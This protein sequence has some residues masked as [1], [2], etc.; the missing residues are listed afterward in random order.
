MAVDVDGTLLD[1]EF[2]D[3]MRPR[4]QEAINRVREAGHLVAFCTGRNSRSLN[5][6][7]ARSGMAMTD[8][9][10]VLLNGA[11]IFGGDPW[12]KLYAWSLEQV[13]LQRLV[14]IFR[15][16]HA[17]AM[18]Y[19]TEERGGTLF[20]ED[21]D[22]NPILYQ[23]LTRRRHTVG[24]VVAVEDLLEHL[25]RTALEVGTIDTWEK[26]KGLTAQIREELGSEVKV[27]NTETL[28]SREQ[29]SWTEVY[30]HACS[31]GEGA[32]LLAA[33]YG[34]DPQNIIAVG[35][36][37]NDLDLFAAARVSVAMANGPAA[38]REAADHIAPPVAESGAAQ[39]LEAI[40]AG[41]FPA[42]EV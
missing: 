3:E 36:N 20:H 7:L 8:S 15:L 31:K 11:V 30:H 40:A 16:H 37:Y 39:I 23:Y 28:L 22:T 14:E 12:R 29:F 2:E 17:V 34:I 24:A 1:T 6:V 35:D 9:P 5:A 41:T 21:L 19:D 32:R 4:E 18:I 25:P 27:V 13:V 33:E 42:R 10:M 38:V 26:V